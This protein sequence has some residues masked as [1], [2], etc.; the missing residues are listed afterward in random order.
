MAVIKLQIDVYKPLQMLHING[1]NLSK[2]FAFVNTPQL[3][4]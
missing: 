3:R 2:L 1:Y 4:F